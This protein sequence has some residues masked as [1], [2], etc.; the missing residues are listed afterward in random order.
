MSKIEVKKGAGADPRTVVVG[1]IG[2]RTFPFLARLTHQSRKPLVV[3]SSGINSLIPGGEGVEVKLKSFEQVWTLVTDLA[4]LA[5]HSKSKADTF[6]EIEVADETAVET[7]VET[8]AETPVE[9]PAPTATKAK[10][11]ATAGDAV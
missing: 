8:S 10:A 5:E 11:K 9:A 2:E 4:T 6:A 7:P 3:P 1:F